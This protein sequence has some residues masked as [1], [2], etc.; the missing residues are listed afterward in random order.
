[1]LTEPVCN[2]KP[3]AIFGSAPD[4]DLASIRHGLLNNTIIMCANGGARIAHDL[5]YSVNVM[6]TTTYLYRSDASPSEVEIRESIQD[7]EVGSVWIDASS[8]PEMAKSIMPFS[9]RSRIIVLPSIERSEIVRYACGA[10]LRVS[11]GVFLA[12]LAFASGA[13]KI[14]IIGIN[15]GT[16][17]HFNSKHNSPRDH[18]SEDIAALSIL[19]D[20]LC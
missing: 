3:C 16:T 18:V 10:P 14:T 5:G 2:N 19:G 11:T 8:N 17:G 12:C 4:I 7:I 15:P 13:S 9:T 6:G 20:R 1:M